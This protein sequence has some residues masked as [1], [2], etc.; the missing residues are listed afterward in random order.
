MM[1][2]FNFIKVKFFSSCSQ[3]GRPGLL[4]NKKTSHTKR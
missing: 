3:R 1:K 4:I 2:E